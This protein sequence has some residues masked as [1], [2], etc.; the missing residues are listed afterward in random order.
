MKNKVSNPKLLVVLAVIF[1]AFIG[2]TLKL[3]ASSKTFT[4]VAILM[5]ASSVVNY[6]YYK[7]TAKGEPFTFNFKLVF[8]SLCGYFFYWVFY[9]SAIEYYDEMVSPP[10][11]LNYTWPFFTGLFTIFIYKRQQADWVFYLTLLCGFLGIMVLASEGSSGN[12]NFS[13]STLGLVFGILTGLSYGLFSSYASQFERPVDNARFLL[14]G[15]SLSAILLGMLSF[16]KYGTSMFDL[17]TLDWTIALIDGLLL[18]SFGYILWT[19]AQA[20][21]ARDRI[22]VTKVISL[23]NYL[24][25]FSL[26]LVAIFSKEERDIIFQPYFL[27][28]FA[29]VLLSSL[30]PNFINYRE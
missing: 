21:A 30:I 6:F 10:I 18:D 12:L 27:V 24:P 29:L 17:S 16:Y 4:I 20:I 28:A 25:I 1:W 7:K 8:F 22:D 14:L 23:A 9:L 11:I 2:L 26:T 13:Y 15:T 3:V 19:R 5:L